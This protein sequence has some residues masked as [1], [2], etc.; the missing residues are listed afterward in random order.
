MNLVAKEASK[1]VEEG[2]TDV[3][4]EQ[5]ALQVRPDCTCAWFDHI[6]MFLGA[7]LRSSFC[8]V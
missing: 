3:A 6:Q 1:Q 4:A 8:W 2:G 7:R 5:T